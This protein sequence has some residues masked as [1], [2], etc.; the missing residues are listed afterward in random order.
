VRSVA[1]VSCPSCG[2]AWPARTSRF[3]GRCGDALTLGQDLRPRRRLPRGAVIAGTLGVAAAALAG[4]TAVG[5]QVVDAVSARPDPEVELPRSS[6]IPAQRGLT[7][8]EAEAALAPFDPD[9]LRCEPAGCE[10]WRL[11]LPEG[12]DDAVRFGD[13]LV[14][15]TEGELVGLELTSGERRWEVTLDDVDGD[16]ASDR[17]GTRLSAVGDDHLVIAGETG[18]LQV[19]DQ[20]G[21]RRWQVPA[22]SPAWIWEVHAVAG[23]VLTVGPPPSPA[24]G[25]TQ[26]HAFDVRDG[27]PRW[28]TVVNELVHADDQLL[29]IT[30]DEQ[31]VRLDPESGAVV[32]SLGG[33]AWA[34]PLTEDLLLLWHPDSD[35]TTV[36][37]ADDGAP[38]LTL[39]GAI[40]T[41]LEGDGTVFLQVQ[42]VQRPD[43]RE[44]VALGLDGELRWRRRVP[45]DLRG[46][47][48]PGL[49]ATD[50]GELF[51]ADPDGG[52]W[53]L[54]Q[55]TGADRP[56]RDLPPIPPGDW[57]T[58]NLAVQ[59]GPGGQLR[60]T[61][62]DG[63]ALVPTPTAW[64]LLDEPVVLA[65]RGGLLAVDLLPPPVG[66]RP[67]TRLPAS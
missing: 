17:T 9:R 24:L 40:D 16:A 66:P 45:L 60:L 44:I 52:G 25:S 62:A 19:F 28:S 58:G 37:D 5:A 7:G 48:C 46:G 8:Q 29:A 11:D 65:G 1:T 6:E 57:W 13:L 63:S 27:T 26:L 31:L 30:D 51:V 32:A 55:T 34:A 39:D 20:E 42:D 33:A 67:P 38:H 18:D 53:L 12:V 2:R 22:P 59:H 41:T 43:E 50:E 23:V 14:L 35:L 3:C 36:V 49:A 61:G 15:Q 47:C 4:M 56:H 21:R 10:R 54:D 64:L